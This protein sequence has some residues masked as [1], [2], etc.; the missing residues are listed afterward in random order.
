M[1]FTIN[2]V[3]IL[4]LTLLSHF[5]SIRPRIGIG[6]GIQ[7]KRIGI[8]LELKTGRRNCIGIGLEL[9]TRRRNCIGIGFKLKIR[10]CPS[11]VVSQEPVLF[12]CSIEEN[13]TYGL[14]NVDHDDVVAAA[15]AANIHDFIC[16][17]PE[18]GRR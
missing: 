14:V 4:F 5:F 9:K 18:V 17:L 11:L 2:H 12:D 6:I 13:I 1:I 8:G 10:K 3:L 16:S 7:T 15:K